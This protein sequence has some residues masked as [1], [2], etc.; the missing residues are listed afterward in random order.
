MI[1]S[2]AVAAAPVMLA[3][4]GSDSAPGAEDVPKVRLVQVTGYT[5]APAPSAE[6]RT[7]D[8]EVLHNVVEGY[9]RTLYYTNELRNQ[10]GR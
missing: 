1:A 4:A 9:R 6:D 8:L 10:M 7:Q 3:Q 2:L 5:P